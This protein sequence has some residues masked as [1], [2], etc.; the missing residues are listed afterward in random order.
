MS[1]F[2]PLFFEGSEK[3]I[4]FL[5]SSKT[6]SLRR[7]PRSFWEKLVETAGAQILSEV[8]NDSMDAYLLSESSLFVYEDGLTM[9]TCGR[10]Q[11]IS[12]VEMLMN[13]YPAE[14]I[15]AFFY[16]R[17]HEVFARY[18]ASHFYEDVLK[19]NKWFDGE[20][21]R[22]GHEDDHH[23]FL[24]STKKNY[25]PRK[26]DHTMEVLMH[27]VSDD[28][29]KL[30]RKDLGDQTL[31]QTSQIDT[32]V[33]GKVDDYLF[34]PCGYSLNAIDKDNYYTIHVTPEKI[35]NYTS[36]ETDAKSFDEQFQ[37]AEKVVRVFRP[38]A[39]DLV[40]FNPGETPPFDGAFEGYQLKNHFRQQIRSG[41]S[42]NFLTFYQ[43][44]DRV[45]EAF[46][47]HEGDL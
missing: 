5:F 42:V 8:S 15:D 7:Q 24:Y 39:F 20:A 29:V 10:T 27:G 21:M 37:L 31:L 4:E 23:L 43:P 46:M 35:G 25:S 9:I 19:L 18:Q 30:F 22:F 32:L 36:F 26:D 6:P 41:Y 14:D 13:T 47:I 1:S 16:E 17:K 34:D 44:Q 28:Q 11:L 33:S 40:L 2:P 45:Q 12:A 38:N 3:K